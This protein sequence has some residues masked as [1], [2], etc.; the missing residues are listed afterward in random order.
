VSPIGGGQRLIVKIIP[1]VGYGVNGI[2]EGPPFTVPDIQY[3]KIALN[4]PEG[5]KC[6][7]GGVI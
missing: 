5:L 6:V 4:F 1:G 7:T 2:L 3:V